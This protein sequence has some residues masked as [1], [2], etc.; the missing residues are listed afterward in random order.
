MKNLI[1]LLGL[2]ALLFWSSCETD[3][4]LEG[5]WKDI[6][7]VYSFL[8]EQD[9]AHYVRVQR[10]F[11]EPGGNAVEIAQNPDSIYYKA[12]EITVTL[13]NGNNTVELT[14]VDGTAEG[15]PREGGDFA[16]TPNIL[17]KASKADADLSGG[18]IAQ[19][20][21][22][23]ND[24][25][26]AEATITMVEKISFS[27][28]PL[29][30]LAVGR[31]YSSANNSIDFL[32]EGD[33]AS[34][35]DVR[36]IFRYNE[37]DPNNPSARVVR[38]VVWVLAESLA[39]D[40]DTNTQRYTYSGESFYQFLGDAIDPIDDGNRQFEEIFYEVTAAGS[41][42]GAYLDISSANIGITSAQAVPIY[43][44]VDG[45]VGVV[46]SR[47]TVRSSSVGLNSESRDSLFNGFYTRDLNFVP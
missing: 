23:R 14:R 36:M 18:D 30:G 8:S 2:L 28:L 44:N 21:I 20:S 31:N 13:Q 25:I 12:D 7:V 10:A 35:F 41:E 15:Y 1:F 24:E 22:M 45:G 47:Y 42:I 5:E 11:L 27:F 46:S 4:T 19:L 43:S 9:T 37:P 39:R 32:P 40:E 33:E 38:E 34:V 6:P 16:T 29:N 17:Y 26:T 3:F